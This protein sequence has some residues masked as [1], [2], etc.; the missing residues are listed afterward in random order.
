MIARGRRWR[1]RLATAAEDDFRNIL[2]WTSERIGEAQARIYAETLV[3][4]I[5]SLTAGADVPGSRKRDEIAE[6]LMT[7]HMAR[8]GRKGRHFVLYRVGRPEEPLIIDALRLLHDSMD[9]IRHVG[10]GGE[11]S[12]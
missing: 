6:G 7:L 9:L 12:Q 11:E 1:I 8:R 5:E 2:L 3:R 4:A 10:T